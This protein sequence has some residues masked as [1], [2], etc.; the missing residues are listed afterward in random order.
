MKKRLITLMAVAV[1]LIAS[2]IPAS[3]AVFT[4]SAE[5]KVAPTVTVLTATIGD[6]DVQASDV[7]VYSMS[8]YSSDDFDAAIAAVEAATDVEDLVGS[9]GMLSPSVSCLYYVVISDDLQDAL[10][11]NEDESL[12]IQLTNSVR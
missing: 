12:Q 5:N 3:A 1:L 11:A 2:V 8:D 9:T 7:T 6:Y 4:D 10:D